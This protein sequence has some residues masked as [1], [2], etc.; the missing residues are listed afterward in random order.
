MD[1]FLL[2]SSGR[3]SDAIRTVVKQSFP[4]VGMS[5]IVTKEVLLQSS[6]IITSRI[7]GS[8]R[9]RFSWGSSRI[10]GSYL[11]G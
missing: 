10:G 6:G 2:T 5:N 11:I 9:E 8:K 7:P 1:N 4:S 3:L